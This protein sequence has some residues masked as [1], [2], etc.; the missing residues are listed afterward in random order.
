MQLEGEKMN[1]INFPDEYGVNPKTYKVIRFY[2]TSG[3]RKIIHRGLT[4]ELAKLHC[5]SPGTRKVNSKGE[6]V[7]FEGFEEE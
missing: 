5:N 1:P 4:R 2:R 7:W 6:T 3:R